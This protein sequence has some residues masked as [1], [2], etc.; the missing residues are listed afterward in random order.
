LPGSVNINAEVH[1][2][3][4]NSTRLFLK[5]KKMLNLNVAMVNISPSL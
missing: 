5:K 2:V 4:S 3:A 1:L